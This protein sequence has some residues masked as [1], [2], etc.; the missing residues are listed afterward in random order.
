[1]SPLAGD[2]HARGGQERRQ[3]QPTDRLPRDRRRQEDRDAVGHEAERLVRRRHLR[4]VRHV[5]AAKQEHGA[6]DER[7]VPANAQQ[8][9]PEEEVRLTFAQDADDHA[10]R[11]QQEPHPHDRRLAQPSNEVA[12][13]QAWDEHHQHVEHDATADPEI[14][15]VQVRQM[16]G[17]G[18]R[19]GRHWHDHC[20][21]HSD[22]GKDR[23]PD[24]PP[25][26][27][28]AQSRPA[29]GRPPS[30]EGRQPEA[31]RREHEDEAQA[32]HDQK[33]VGVP[34]DGV[35]GLQTLGEGGAERPDHRQ[36]SPAA[37]DAR[38]GAAPAGLVGDCLGDGE[39]H[40]LGHADRR[41][42]QHDDVEED[43]RQHLTR[44]EPQREEHADAPEDGEA[45]AQREAEPPAVPPH[46]DRV[47][48][49]HHNV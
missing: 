35:V 23:G 47:R 45:A 26:Q 41:D 32:G 8:C 49:G 46:E 43:V 33:E 24:R 34:L 28:A 19:D 15:R 27:H 16:S 21:L 29:S 14:R 4:P 42:E 12:S 18:Q 13:P 11:L 2:H 6:P 44:T 31:D 20:E 25:P 3:S 36:H 48:G 38:H 37:D 39:A 1:M 40:E 7:H 22:L 30:V 10:T 17:H 9:H 5:M